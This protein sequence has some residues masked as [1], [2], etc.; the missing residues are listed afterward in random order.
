MDN[1]EEIKELLLELGL[2]RDSQADLRNR[3]FELNMRQLDRL[4]QMLLRV[5][6]TNK[7]LFSEETRLGIRGND[8]VSFTEAVFSV[9][10]RLK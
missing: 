10:L 9:N 2:N 4:K 7:D 3:I 8:L 6:Q 5:D 1:Y